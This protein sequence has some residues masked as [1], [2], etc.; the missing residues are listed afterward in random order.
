MCCF[1]F[2]SS[3]RRHT[4]CALVTGVQTVLFRSV[5]FKFIAPAVLEIS[6]DRMQETV[7]GVSLP[8]V[9]LAI[10]EVAY[11]NTPYRVPVVASADER[12]ADGEEA[13]HGKL[14][15]ALA[16]KTI[17]LA[18]LGVGSLIFILGLF[19]T[20]GKIAVLI[21]ALVIVMLG[22]MLLLS[23]RRSQQRVKG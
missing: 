7:L 18:L 8:I 21:I 12:V 9:L 23:S 15:G 14:Q 19:A 10:F 4:R 2:F 6:L 5:F 16:I 1:F 3:R 17:A 20:H 22:V 13:L 11:R